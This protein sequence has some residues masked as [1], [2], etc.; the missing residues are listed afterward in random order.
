MKKL[1]AAALLSALIGAAMLCSCD[2]PLPFDEESSS[3]AVLTTTVSTQDRNRTTTT[4]KSYAIKGEEKEYTTSTRKKTEEEDIDESS[5]ERV[6]VYTKATTGKKEISLTTTTTTAR[7]QYN[8]LQ[9]PKDKEY[10]QIVKQYR[11]SKDTPL[12]FG[13]S[14][15]YAAQASLPAGTSLSCYGQSGK[16]YYVLYNN[17]TYGWVEEGSLEGIAKKTTTKKK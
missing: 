2:I 17:T 12:R 7:S 1:G 5:M 15:D 3:E 6:S 4:T 16:W 8:T 14:N 10:Y 11:T 9:Q 13:P